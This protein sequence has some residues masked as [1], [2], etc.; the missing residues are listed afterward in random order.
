MTSNSHAPRWG[1][2]IHIPFCS[3]LCSYCDFAKTSRYSDADVQSYLDVLTKHLIQGF[4]WLKIE[5]GAVPKFNSVFFGGGTPGLL[6][7]EY[8][9]IFR[10]FESYLIDGAEISLEVN[11]ENVSAE[12]IRIWRDLGFNRV[13]MGVQ[14]FNPRGLKSLGRNHDVKRA[15]DATEMLLRTFPNLNL[16]LIYGWQ[17]QTMEEWRQDLR[18]AIDLAVPHLSLYNLIFESGTPLGRQVLRRGTE[19]HSD[20]SL[21]LMY[22]SACEILAL[23]G[24]EH[25][26]VSNWSRPGF[27]CVHNWIY[28]DNDFYLSVGAGSHGHLI[29]GDGQQW[30]TAMTTHWRRFVLQGESA[31]VFP[32]SEIDSELF[33]SS[34]LTREE[35][36]TE[37]VATSLR[38]CKGVNLARL[39]QFSGREFRPTAAMQQAI[40]SGQILIQNNHLILKP[41]EWFREQYWAVELLRSY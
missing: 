10:S 20:E 35:V 22:A 27:S 30:R 39:K 3:Q 4:E 25:E 32:L 29:S 15:V 34:R 17:S 9:S 37:I 16:D 36:L 33:E 28:W 14:S 5:H 1:L 26:E 41:A 40:A 13:S 7:R 8:E 2:Y 6:G 24:F 31:A 12:N 18:Q 19:Y 21:E 11:P 23:A 38:T